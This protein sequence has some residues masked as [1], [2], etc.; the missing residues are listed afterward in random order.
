[1]RSTAELTEVETLFASGLNDCQISRRTGIPRS[2]ARDWRHAGF[3]RP[4]R[5]RS[6]RR[7]A[8][9]TH[10][11][12]LLPPSYAYLLGLYLGDGCISRHARGV[13]RLRITLDMRYRLIIS[14]CRDAMAEVDAS[15][16]GVGAASTRRSLRRS[17]L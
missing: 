14:A 7:P 13:H 2:T 9:H 10:D 11:F 16:P 5:R 17:Q 12:G 4:E 15:E 6:A 1:M 8:P 3:K